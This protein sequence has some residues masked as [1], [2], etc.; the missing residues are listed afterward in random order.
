MWQFHEQKKVQKFMSQSLCVCYK[1]SHEQDQN[2]II[3]AYHGQLK[4]QSAFYL[5]MPLD[6]CEVLHSYIFFFKK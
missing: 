5:F 3:I 4:D 6:H 2:I 1:F